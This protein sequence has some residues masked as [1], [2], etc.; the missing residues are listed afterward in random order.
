MTYVEELGRWIVTYTAFGREGP[1]VSLAQTED[2]RTFERLGM[3]M[4]PEDKN[5][6]LLPRR[7]DGDW[8]LFHRPTSVQG[9][10][11][12][13]SRSSDLKSW[14]SPERVMGRRAGGWWDSARIGMGAAAARDRARLARRLPRRA[15]DRRGRPVPRRP[16][17]AR[18]RRA[19]DRAATLG[20][21]GARARAPTTRS[22]ATSPN[23]VF[24]CGLVHEPESDKLFLYY[25]AADTRIGLATASLLRGP[26]VPAGAARPG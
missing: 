20:G 13:L 22:R 8:V 14:R 11:V 15:P 7:I 4:S 3:V 5:A 16:R 17:A 21:V 6:V 24:P 9:A 10:D 23:V 1:G 2:F 12:W 18:P 19:R 26:R 25:G